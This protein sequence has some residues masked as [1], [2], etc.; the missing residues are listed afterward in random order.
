MSD[1]GRGYAY[2]LGLFLAHAERRFPAFGGNEHSLWFNGAA[3]HLYDLEIPKILPKK[4]KKEIEK[5]RD[6]CL[7]LRLCMNGEKCTE[8]DI[9][10]AL[11]K[12]KKFLREWDKA[13]DIPSEKGEWE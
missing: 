5:W 6:R 4:K 13:C 3:D 2:C 12:A 1:F 7:V 8:K 10:I 11:E 9:F